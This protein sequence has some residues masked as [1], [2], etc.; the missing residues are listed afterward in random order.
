[1]TPSRY[2]LSSVT[3]AQKYNGRNILMC[4]I[5]AIGG[6]GGGNQNLITVDTLR[7]LA[8]HIHNKQERDKNELREEM[9]VGMDEVSE[10]IY[11]K[12]VRERRVL[13]KLTRVRR[14]RTRVRRR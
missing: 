11:E 8:V 5:T 14:R 12:K 13:C 6:G 4:I 9:R 7:A 1:M 3:R 2:G 10:K